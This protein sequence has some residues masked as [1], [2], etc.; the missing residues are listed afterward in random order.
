MVLSLTAAGC[1]PST[2]SSPA[3]VQPGAPGEPTRPADPASAAA[4]QAPTAAD[5]HFIQGMIRHHAQAL[6]LTRLVPERTG[7]EQIR[8][9]SRRIELSQLDEIAMMERWLVRH[10]VEMP[11]T[12]LGDHSNG[13]LMPGMF[14]REQIAALASTSGREFDRLF[15]EL[16]IRHHE[17]AL[18]MVEEL[19]STPGAAQDPELDQFASHVDSDQRLEIA[20]MSRMLAALG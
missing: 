7:S 9:L 1:A 10:T 13:H 16:M 12:P 11:A 15:L 5:L 3:I 4:R 17:G 20:R 6:D 14:T 19:R 8:L 18:V 2:V